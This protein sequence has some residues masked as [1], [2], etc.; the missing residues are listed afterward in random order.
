[1]STTPALRTLAAAQFTCCAPTVPTVVAAASSTHIS[2]G[3][4]SG[5]PVWGTV[6]SRG[7]LRLR[8]EPTSPTS[9]SPAERLRLERLGSQ[10]QLQ[11]ERLQLERPLRL[12]Q[13]V[14]VR[15]PL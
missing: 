3:A 13:L 5:G 14:R 8:S 7:G 12:E 11:Q 2:G 1:M 15:R 6:V 9:N 4:G 10:R